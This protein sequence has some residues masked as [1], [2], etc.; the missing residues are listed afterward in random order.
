[1][2]KF[3]FKDPAPKKTEKIKIAEWD[4][5]EMFVL[6]ELSANEAKKIVELA[7]KVNKEDAGEN[8]DFNAEIVSLCLTNEA[9][10]RPSKEWLLAGGVSTLKDLTR[11]CLNLNGVGQE[12]QEKIEKN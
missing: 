11:K 2:G 3:N 9:G 1:V 12:A 10:E 4:P 8:L 6:H 5:D 7:D